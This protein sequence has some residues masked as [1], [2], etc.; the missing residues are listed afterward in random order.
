MYKRIFLSLTVAFAASPLFAGSLGGLAVTGTVW[1]NQVALPSGSS[2]YEGDQVRTDAN[3]MAVLGAGAKRFEIRP[4][5]LVTLRTGGM[6]LHQG[7]VG[8][9]GSS[10]LL[11]GA[12][13]STADAASDAW[14]VV[15][16]ANGETLVAAYRGDAEIRDRNGRR[17]IVPQGSFALAAAMPQA[18]SSSN[19]RPQAN[20]SPAAQ[21]S[22][23]WL[24][25]KIVSPTGAIIVTGAAVATAT[26]FVIAQD[27]ESVSPK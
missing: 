19:S 16:E 21:K 26:G 20:A 27:D 9:S 4:E 23:P 13:V 22:K 24:V 17:T 5:S 8:S 14:F 6:E 3:S 15:K 18:S 10:V 7:V 25:R 2:V 1:T 12:E 11:D